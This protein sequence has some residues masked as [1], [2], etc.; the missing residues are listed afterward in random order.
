V[1]GHGCVLRLWWV[2]RNFLSLSLFR[3]DERNDVDRIVGPVLAL[4]D[5]DRV[6]VAAGGMS[7]C[8]GAVVQA[9]VT[10][11]SYHFSK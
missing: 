4:T 7:A 8:L 10:V 2:R 6:L 11:D 9:P 3:G 5:S 1:G